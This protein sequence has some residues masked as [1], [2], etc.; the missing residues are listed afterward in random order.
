MTDN[1]LFYLQND[2]SIRFVCFYQPLIRDFAG[3]RLNF[4]NNLAI[5]GGDHIYGTGIRNFCKVTKFRLAQKE[6]DEWHSIFTMTQR[7]GSYSPIS[8]APMRI[9]LCD[10]QGNQTPQCDSSK[11]IFSSLN[12]E[13][14]P[15]ELFNVSVVIVGAEFGATV[16]PVYAKLL[17]NEPVY[18]SVSSSSF[19]SEYQEIQYVRSSYPCTTLSYSIWSTNPSEI[20]YLTSTNITL[21]MKHYGDTRE[22]IKNAIG[23]FKNTSV[24]PVSLLTTPVF[25]NVTLHECPKGFMMTKQRFCDCYSEL[26]LYNNIT[27][28]FKDGRGYVSREENNW[29]GVDDKSSQLES[30]ASSFMFNS[31][32]PYDNCVKQSVSIDL[33]IQT[34]PDRQCAYDH[35]GVLCGGCK[36]NYSVAI[37]SSHCLYCPSN[38]YL[39]LF[40]FFVAAGPL[41]YILIAILNLTITKGTINGLLFYANIVWIYQNI[42]FPSSEY[43]TNGPNRAIIHT[44]RGFIAWLNLDFGIET[45]LIKGLDA[46]W[47]SMLQYAFP[48]YIWVIAGAVIAFYRYF[49]VNKFQKNHRYVAKLTGNPVD[50][51]VTFILLSYTKLIRTIKDAFGFAILTSYPDKSTKMIWALDGNVDYLKGKHLASFIIAALILI[52]TLLYTA[53]IIVMGLKPYLC[54]CN[55]AMQEQEDQEVEN[56][57]QTRKCKPC[58]VNKILNFMDMPLPLSNAHFASLDDGHRYWLGLTLLILIVDFY[59]SV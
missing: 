27:C 49:D 38:K 50:V 17:K 18:H 12:H 26:R 6:L 47:K 10:T 48:L 31:H 35:S 28:L 40:L 1:H 56:R 25:I 36:T 30:S 59:C 45:C 58:Q 51:L 8:S 44:L 46:F 16:G 13:V 19:G 29:I 53:Y 39:L 57:E 24:I 34:D 22:E 54:E 55:T 41:L 43:L 14:Y 23:D 33:E 9:C 37:G 3:I 42:L 11:K 4:I 5:R 20:I 2:Y 21:T 7:T 52:A 15:G 32:C